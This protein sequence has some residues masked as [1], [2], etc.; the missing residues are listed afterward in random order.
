MDTVILS[1]RQML[2]A[3]AVAHSHEKLMQL[4]VLEQCYEKAELL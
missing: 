2:Q 1:E 3:N 4:V